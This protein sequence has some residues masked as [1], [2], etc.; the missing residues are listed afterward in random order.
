MENKGNIV[1]TI[2]GSTTGV[3]IQRL[4]ETLAG[5]QAPEN[6]M[7]KKKI[8]TKAIDE[9]EEEESD[10]EDEAPKAKSKKKKKAAVEDE[11]DEEEESD[12]SDSD[13][14]D[15]SESDEEDSDDESEDSDDEEESGPTF[16]DVEAAL[17][18]VGKSK[19]H[20]ADAAKKI[21]STHNMKS[22]RELNVKANKKYFAP[23]L[24]KCKKLLA[25]K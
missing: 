12:E 4:Q 15:D 25:K 19:K 20:G 14:E 23:I 10:E 16:K 22:M 6:K 8:A 13:D 18:K 21:L 7:A 24:T 11:E 17:I 9:D 3:I 2:Q 1:V 5:F